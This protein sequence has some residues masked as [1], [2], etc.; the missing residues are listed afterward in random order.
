[1]KKND[2]RTRTRFLVKYR[3]L[4]LYDIEFGRRYYI[5]NENIHFLKGDRYA[6]I[7]NSDHPDGTSTDNEYFLHS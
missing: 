5:D 1:M 2:Q 4:S 6:L 7:G 3:E